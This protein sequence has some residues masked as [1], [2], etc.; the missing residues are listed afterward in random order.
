NLASLLLARAAGRRKEIAVRL[1]LGA[2]RGRLIS[3]LLAESVSLALAGGAA[4]WLLARW[5]VGLVTALKPPI[6]FALR[7]DLKLD[8]RVLLFTLVTSLA[9][10]VLFGLAPALQSTRF[11]LTAA[12]KAET[13]VAGDRRSR[14]RNGLVVAQVA[15][16]LVLLVV[17]GLL[18][19]SLQQV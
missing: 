12:L 10:G 4:G 5:I 2:R 9:T 7:I 18:V 15:L 8:W 3:Q 1:S 13:S 14:L 16:S 11:E 6:D 17:A 19:R